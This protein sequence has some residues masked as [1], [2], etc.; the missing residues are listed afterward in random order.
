M[1]TWL[2]WIGM[3][4]AFL[5]LEGHAQYS[6]NYQ[7]NVISGV[8]NTWPGIYY[9]G[10]NY[11]GD[12]LL[13]RN[14]GVLYSTD[15]YV[16]Y[17]SGTSGNVARVTG[18]GSAWSNSADLYIGYYGSGNTLAISNGA[19]V[20]SA[21]GY[22]G[23]DTN[24]GNNAVLVSGSGSAW[25][26][27]GS[28]A[29][30]GGVNNTLT[31][32][33]AGACSLGS[34]QV[35]ASSTVTIAGTPL[36]T[37]GVGVSGQM[38]VSNCAWSGDN[39]TAW[40]QQGL[41]TIAGGTTVVSTI[42]AGTAANSTGTVDISDA[43]LS[44]ASISVYNY[45]GNSGGIGRMTVSNSDWSSLYDL[46]VGD[47]GGFG[48]LNVVNSTMNNNIY[49]IYVGGLDGAIHPTGTGNVCFNGGELA[50]RR[51]NGMVILGG[52]Y[53]S[54]PGQMTFTN[55]I[56]WVNTFQ[57]GAHAPSTLTI[58][59]GSTIKTIFLSIGPSGTVFLAGGQLATTNSANMRDGAS[60]T[61]FPGN[62]VI[63][64]GQMTVSGGSWDAGNVYFDVNVSSPP[65]S[66]TI[67][68]GTNSFLGRLWLGGAD[69]TNG[70]GVSTN[71]PGVVSIT[72]GLLVT[73]NA[74]TPI[75]YYG[76]GQLTASGGT[77]IAQD[78]YVAQYAGSTGI[79]TIAGGNVILNHLIAT[80]AGSSFALN[81]G[82]L[83][84]RGAVLP[85]SLFTIGDGTNAAILNLLTG[86]PCWNA[87]SVLVSSNSTLNF[88]ETT[89][90]PGVIT[91]CGTVSVA[92]GQAGSIE[93][94]FTTT[95][96]IV[97]YPDSFLNVT[98]AW[99][100]PGVITLGEDSVLGGATINNTG[101]I[102]G[103]GV[104]NAPLINAPSGQIQLA[105]GDW[106][107]LRNF[108]LNQGS[109]TNLG[110]LFDVMAACFT[111][112][113][114]MSGYGIFSGSAMVNQ[115]SVLF[116]GGAST[117]YGGYLNAN[118]ATTVAESVTAAFYGTVTNNGTMQGINGGKLEFYGRVV[119][120][121]LISYVLGG[122]VFHGTNGVDDTDFK[123]AIAD[124]TLVNNGIVLSPDDDYDGDG[125]NN[126][127]EYVGTSDPTNSASYFHAWTFSNDA[128]RRIYF[129]PSSTGRLY[130]L[131]VSTDILNGAWT[132]V[133]GQTN[134]TGA[135]AWLTDT[136]AAAT[137]RFY[138]V[139]VALP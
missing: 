128:N 111:N 104:I 119:N 5:P 32:L 30:G 2:A 33:D 80:N 53:G 82:S 43:R 135:P 92:A 63:R 75:G 15:G 96:A 3:G 107:T 79:F 34:V 50:V 117:F 1:R 66:L 77:W 84:I 11:V 16:G 102:Q 24:A 22:I 101:L 37:A 26:N 127:Q 25:N 7:T 42:N 71:G 133:P 106:L 91:N 134:V 86:D 14:T 94:L 122:A 70:T 44:T 100:N 130:S 64:G 29:V 4:L 59:D 61:V 55:A 131:L 72:G 27:S 12:V 23:A 136:N 98:L 69:S 120:N 93:N 108:T 110:A 116:Q 125:Q 17:S 65:G 54:T 57:I 118:G 36:N 46:I 8:T 41:L 67:A 90:A 88:A 138:R 78:V 103:G 68:G 113:G 58:A 45:I 139:N 10:S 40:G 18:A 129:T 28:L 109:I 83:S 52:M 99:T 95:G 56:A 35:G 114:T 13:I 123:Q 20:Y 74:P 137:P 124:G 6:G 121:G 87:Y 19:A 38:T 105:A 47:N 132:G 115:G 97:L 85:T 9:V 21:N 60:D 112:A 51:A 81:S 76:A 49:R 31:V 126:L 39:V 48:T 62:C 89:D 73:T